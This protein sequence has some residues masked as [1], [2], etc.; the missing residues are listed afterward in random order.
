V[1]PQNTQY[2]SVAG[3]LFNNSQTTL[4]ACPSGRAG[5]YTVPNGVTNIGDEALAHCPL[6]SV[7]IP[8]SITH[9]GTFAFGLCT[10]LTSV[11]IGNGVTRIEGLAFDRCFALTSVYFQ[12]NA[13]AGGPRQVIDGHKIAGEHIRRTK[14]G[15]ITL[16]IDAG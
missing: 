16:E 1:N 12:G 7:T 11:T 5:A 13:P 14:A 10:N 15:G 6:T 9:I 4:I 8:D 3:V 2:S